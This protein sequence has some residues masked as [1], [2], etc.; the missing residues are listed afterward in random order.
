MSTVFYVPCPPNFVL[1]VWPARTSWI[2][3]RSWTTTSTEEYDAS[4]ND[5]I[6]TYAVSG[7]TMAN[8]L[9]FFCD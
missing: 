2:S 7:R 1:Q 4:L 3:R 6:K 9:L 8:K 5:A